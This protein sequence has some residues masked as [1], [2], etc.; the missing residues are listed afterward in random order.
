MSG[1]SIRIFQW[2]DGSGLINFGDQMTLYLLE[3]LADLTV[4]RASIQTAELIGV[5]SVLDIVLSHANRPDLTIFGSGFIEKGPEAAP[6]FKVLAV[7]GA[8]TRARLNIDAPL[9]DPG[10][11]FGKIIPPQKKRWRLGVVPHYADNLKRGDLPKGVRFINVRQNPI[12]VSLDIAACDFIVSSSLHGLVVADALGI[13]N[14][15]LSFQGLV[16]GD[17]K[18]RDYYSA[19]DMDD[20]G[21]IAQKDLFRFDMFEKMASGYA[22][23]GLDRIV[24]DLSAALRTLAV[25]GRT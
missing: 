11:L 5:G 3:H 12:K 16:G 2:N 7:R 20:P 6:R 25:T 19:F 24:E 22:R 8:L 18:F 23:P 17:Y 14:V 15:R 10:L 4:L 21:S 1:G 9:G 13:P